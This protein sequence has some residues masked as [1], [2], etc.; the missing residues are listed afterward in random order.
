MKRPWLSLRRFA[1]DQ[2]GVSAVE[3]ALIAPLLIAFYFGMA[4]TTQAMMAKRKS[5]HV[6]SVIGDLIAQDQS[7]TPAEFAD[8]WTIGATLMSPFPTS[9][10]LGMRITSVTANASGTVK[11]DWSCASGTGLTAMTKAATWTGIP[12]GLIAANQSLVIAETLYPYDSPIKKYVPNTLNFSDIYYLRP[13]K[14]AT[15]Q[16][17][18]TC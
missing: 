11:V 13:R 9:G 12:A 15:V 14:I 17:S 1:R 2:R 16:M 6:A 18:S 5:S 7:V 10:Q 4:E 3:F 8:T